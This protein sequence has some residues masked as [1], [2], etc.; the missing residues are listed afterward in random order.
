MQLVL[1]RTPVR[2]L[3]Q[4]RIAVAK[5]LLIRFGGLS[6]LRQMIDNQEAFKKLSG[7]L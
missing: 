5:N 4:E 6:G 3:L 1:F 7:F 2:P